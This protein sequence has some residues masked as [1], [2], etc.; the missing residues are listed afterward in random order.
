MRPHS[1][2]PKINPGQLRFWAAINCVWAIVTG[3]I[4]PLWWLVPLGLA[5]LGLVWRH[6]RRG[7]WP[8]P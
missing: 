7:P 4:T 1:F 6:A 8:P 2:L 5:G 3:L